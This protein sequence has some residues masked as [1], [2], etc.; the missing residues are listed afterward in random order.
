[1]FLEFNENDLRIID[2]ALASQ[3]YGLVAPLIAKINEQLKNVVSPL[4]VVP[5]DFLDC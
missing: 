1:M 2:Q 5:P 4:D 3:P